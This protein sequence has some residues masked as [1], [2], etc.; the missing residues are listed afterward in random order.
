MCE[1]VIILLESL[2]KFQEKGKIPILGIKEDILSTLEAKD[3]NRN[4]L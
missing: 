3:N 1:D 4:N 2:C